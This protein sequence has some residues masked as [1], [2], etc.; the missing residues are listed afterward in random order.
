MKEV[1]APARKTKFNEANV[2]SY[3]SDDYGHFF[4]ACRRPRKEGNEEVHL[5][6]ACAKE[7]NFD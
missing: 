1:K 3:N 5:A 6:P 4:K 2:R 7:V